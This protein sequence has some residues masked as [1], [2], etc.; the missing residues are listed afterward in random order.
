[1]DDFDTNPWNKN[2]FPRRP[3]DVYR[4]PPRQELEKNNAEAVNI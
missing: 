2:I 4:H 1:M 3:F